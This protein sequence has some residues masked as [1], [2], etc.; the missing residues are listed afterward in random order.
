MKRRI[1]FPEAALGLL[2]V[3]LAA[4]AILIAGG[5]CTVMRVH[6]DA[7]QVGQTIYAPAWPWQDSAAAIKK[8]T[9]SAKTNSFNLSL[10]GANIETTGA[11]NLLTISGDAVSILKLLRPTP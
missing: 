5:G 4:F 1:E 10:S 2:S 11:T 8:L 3:T 6:D 9:I 7:R